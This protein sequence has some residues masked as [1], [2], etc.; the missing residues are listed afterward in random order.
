MSAITTY[1][2]SVRVSTEG[3]ALSE[4]ELERTLARALDECTDLEVIATYG[5]K[6]TA[7]VENGL[8]AQRAEQ[9]D[10]TV[11]TR[12]SEGWRG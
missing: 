7:M 10:G 6:I 8:V 4:L 12:V 3:A 5:T 1:Q 2:L 9:P 11:V